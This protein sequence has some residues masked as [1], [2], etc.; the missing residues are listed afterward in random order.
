[1]LVGGGGDVEGWWGVGGSWF[2]QQALY[3]GHR[4][5]FL[6]FPHQTYSV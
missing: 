4:T 5:L 1:M 3:E 6:S 2:T